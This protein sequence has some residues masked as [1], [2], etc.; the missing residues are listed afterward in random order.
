MN[1]DRSSWGESCHWPLSSN[2]TG[3][4]AKAETSVVQGFQDSKNE[5]WLKPYF[6]TS[7][8]LP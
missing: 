7:Q 4:Y 5:L 1:C 2:G 3:S 6:C 8:S